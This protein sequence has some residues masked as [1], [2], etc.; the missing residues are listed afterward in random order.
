MLL[1]LLVP[2]LV[3]GCTKRESPQLSVEGLRYQ[4]FPGGARIV[5]GKLVNKSDVYVGNAQVQLTLFDEHNVGVSSMLILVKDIPASEA[6]PF[7]E[8]V[9]VDMDIRAARVKSVLVL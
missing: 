6:V 9:Q 5:S 4:E 7:R 3:V 2:T 8:P 1:L